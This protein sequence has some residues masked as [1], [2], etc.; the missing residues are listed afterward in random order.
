MGVSIQ[1]V[2]TGGRIR[3]GALRAVATAVVCCSAVPASDAADL[4]A[5]RLALKFRQGS[6]STTEFRSSILE[7]ATLSGRT[8][9]HSATL[10]GTNR[11]IVADVEAWDGA[12]LI[13]QIGQGRWTVA[14]GTNAAGREGRDEIWIAA[15]RVERNGRALTRSVP[16]SDPAAE[17]AKPD[18]IRRALNQLGETSQ[19]CAAFPKQDLAVGSTWSGGVFL[20]LP[21]I[22]QPGQATSRVTAVVPT[23]DTVLYR[24]RSE[25]RSTAKPA[26]HAVAGNAD[27]SEMEVEGVSEGLFDAERGHWRSMTVDLKALVNQRG[28][29]GTIEIRSSAEL[30]SSE[31]LPP[32]LDRTY[33]RRVLRFDAALDRLYARDLQAGLLRLRDLVL[34]E[35]DPE[36]KRALAAVLSLAR[37]LQ[38][39]P[40]ADRREQP[41]ENDSRTP[42]R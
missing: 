37:P 29:A 30:L 11:Q 19:L 12:A 13:G 34:S 9:T 10:I 31:R 4:L 21:G 17:A 15:Y 8:V 41:A 22:R 16:E 36:W 3:R 26:R 25:L 39:Q 32:E 7:T 1:V 2:S 23:N 27:P 38:K 5:R 6:L 18:A 24:I 35:P 42:Q 33:H 40:A 14:D 28:F 20:P